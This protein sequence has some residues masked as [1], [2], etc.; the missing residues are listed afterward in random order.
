M[1]ETLPRNEFNNIE[2]YRFYKYVEVSYKVKGS[3]LDSE[4]VGYLI[5]VSENCF[6]LALDENMEEMYNVESSKLV[7]WLTNMIDTD[8]GGPDVR[9]QQVFHLNDSQFTRMWIGMR[10]LAAKWNSKEEWRH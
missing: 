7:K 9:I 1:K 4:V 8:E 5:H 3:H 6:H 10:D 2:L